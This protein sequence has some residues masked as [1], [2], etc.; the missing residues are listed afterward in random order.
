MINDQPE[1]PF[2]RD[3]EPSPRTASQTKALV[4]AAR[5][6]VG[7]V[8]DADGERLG[9]VTEQAEALSEEY[10]LCLL[11]DLWLED[12][13]GPVVCNVSTTLTMDAVAARHDVPLYRT[14]VGQA[15]VAEGILA[16]DAVLGGEGSGGVIFP[17]YLLAHDALASGAYLLHFLARKEA[18]LSERVS[19]LP[20]YYTVKERIDVGTGSATR[21]LFR[22]REAA[23]AEVSDGELDLTEGVRRVWRN[24]DGSPRAALH[25]RA[26]ITEPI[27]R[28]IGEAETPGE[29]AALAE[30]TVAKLRSV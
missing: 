6:D 12:Q 1:P 18:T 19:R 17:N 7:W 22:Y 27:I 14:R 4:K 3:P 5:A 25:V 26:S 10:T 21:A 2:P 9:L 28:I 11:A 16:H 20:K 24:K 29:A 8:H 30:E 23:E 15:Y 13:R